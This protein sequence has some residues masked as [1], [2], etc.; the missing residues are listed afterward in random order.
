MTHNTNREESAEYY[1]N[2]FKTSAMYAKDAENVGHNHPEIWKLCANY[3]LKIDAKNVVDIGCGPGHLMQILEKKIN[4][5]RYWGYDFSKQAI[6]MANEKNKNKQVYTYTVADVFETDIVSDKPY[7]TVYVS[8][9]F[10]EHVNRDIDVIKKI[11][12]GSK[13]VFSVPN[14]WCKGHVRVF[15]SKKDIFD[16]YGELLEIKNITQLISGSTIRFFC[17]SNKK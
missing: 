12:K 15:K 9:E 4:L 6:S 3:L 13:F 14:F 2:I 11:P 17:V 8:F 1:D 7:D 5:S 16:R 10:L